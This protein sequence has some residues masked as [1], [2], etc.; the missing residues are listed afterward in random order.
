MC[1][2][3]CVCVCVYLYK[4]GKGAVQSPPCSH[5]L[6][7]LVE[8]IKPCFQSSGKVLI[9]LRGTSKLLLEKLTSL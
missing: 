2:C 5:G 1:V 7:Q 4:R 6:A 3:V 9:L 8:H